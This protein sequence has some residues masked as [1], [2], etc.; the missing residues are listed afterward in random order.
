MAI[1]INDITAGMA[2][3]VD[4]G[5]YI[6]TEYHHVKP[7]KGSAFV[8]VRLKNVKTD[9]VLERTFRSAEK[10][11]EVPLEE[12]ELEY[13]YRQDDNFYFMDH[14]SYEEV[15]IP[16]Q[17]LGNGVEDFLLENLAV[18]GI[19]CNNKLVKVVLPN[20]I[21]TQVIETEPGIRGDS[22]R[23]GTK[24]GKIP[25]GASIQI[26]LFISTGDWIKIDTRSGGYV[27]RVQK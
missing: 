3:Q 19:Y 21:I 11:D 20:F 7:G 12:N 2:L 8:R 24:P 16:Q 26:P 1:T 14:S 22:T 4:E 23:A 5:I 9:A 13:L 10:L 27:E 18:T 6:V 25:T 15:S 17:S